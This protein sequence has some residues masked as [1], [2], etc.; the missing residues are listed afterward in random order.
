MAG[1]LRVGVRKGKSV[2]IF[3]LTSKKPRGRTKENEY[4]AIMLCKACWKNTF[5]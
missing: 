3:I 2:G 1:I 5:V 4:S